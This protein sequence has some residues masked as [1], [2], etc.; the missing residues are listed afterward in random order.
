ML[1]FF[2]FEI[3]HSAFDIQYSKFKKRALF[4]HFPAYL[5]GKAEGA[6]DP[7]FRTRPAAAIRKDNFKLIEYF[8]DGVLE[9]YNL[10]QDLSEKNNLA[11]VMPEKTAELR[12]LM[13]TWRKD[14]NAPVPT[15]LNPDYNL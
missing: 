11:D 2:H 8:E 13:L 15:K 12:K 1:K 5:Q 10:K 7:H 9:L 14:I 4:W 6:R 3:S